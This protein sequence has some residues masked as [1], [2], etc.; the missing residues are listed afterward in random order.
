MFYVSAGERHKRAKALLQNVLQRDCVLTLQALAEFFSAATRK[1]QMPL[2]EV[3]AQIEDW[4]SLFP[5]VLPEVNTINR[6]IAAVEQHRL[7]FWDAMLW[8][9]AKEASVTIILTEDG[10]H[11]QVVEGVKYENP[12]VS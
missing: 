4:Q 1:L 6:A 10:Q 9:T 3:R 7:S 12:F 2:A 11:G 5:I 8:A